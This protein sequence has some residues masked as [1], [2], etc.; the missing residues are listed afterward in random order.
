[1]GEGGAV[2]LFCGRGGGGGKGREGT[3][4]EGK[5]VRPRFV[6]FSGSPFSR[7]AGHTDSVI[8]ADIRLLCPNGLLATRLI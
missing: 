3:G 2:T 8:A 1:M 5:D 4:R 6:S 7:L